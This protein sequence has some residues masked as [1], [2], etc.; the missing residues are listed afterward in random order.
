MILNV[1]FDKRKSLANGIAMCG[2][3]IGQLVLPYLMA[4]LIDFFGLKGG[5]LLYSGLH[6][7]IIPA[8]MLMRP[9]S[10]YNRKTA[11]TGAGKKSDTASKGKDDPDKDN[12]A[13]T[14]LDSESAPLHAQANSVRKSKSL[15]SVNSVSKK[16]YQ[17][18]MGSLRHIYGRA[19]QASTGSLVLGLS[20]ESLAA[21][22]GSVSALDSKDSEKSPDGINPRQ[23]STTISN[24]STQQNSVGNIKDVEASQDMDTVKI[25]QSKAQGCFVMFLKRLFDREVMAMPVLSVLFLAVGVGHAGFI[26]ACLF[27]PALSIEM[28]GDKYKGALLLAIMG[29]LDIAGRLGGGAFADLNLIRRSHLIGIAMLITG[30]ANAF[31]VLHPIFGMMVVWSVIMGLLG[32]IYRIL[33]PIVIRD[34]FGLA[35]L[36]SAAGLIYCSMGLIIVPIPSVIGNT[37][38]YSY[39]NTV[40]KL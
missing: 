37:L 20:L 31:L 28:Y 32:G 13:D 19:K 18:S 27:I 30:V 24:P 40:V 11:P 15:H 16:S 33:L 23:R 1:Y 34:Y 21:M 10:F 14:T 5:L 7:N 38:N 9:P 35:K 6:L 36:P 3:S 12:P 2:A 29:V 39:N 4:F 8:S 26:C 22:G 17:G 25:K